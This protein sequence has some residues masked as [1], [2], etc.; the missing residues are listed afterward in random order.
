MTC[1][2]RRKWGK[3]DQERIEREK[4]MKK[5]QTNEGESVCVLERQTQPLLY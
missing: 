3:V 2:I 5:E 4:G 1:I